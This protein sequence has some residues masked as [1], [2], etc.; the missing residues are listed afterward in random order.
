MISLEAWRA[1]I[2]CFANNKCCVPKIFYKG[3]HTSGSTIC[4]SI[5]YL[6]VIFVLPLASSFVYI[7][8]VLVLFLIKDMRTFVYCSNTS[9]TGLMN[10]RVMYLLNDSC[11]MFERYY[12]NVLL[13]SGDI[14]LNP[15]P[16]ACKVCPSR[17]MSIHIKKIVCDYGHRFKSKRG[18]ASNKHATIKPSNEKKKLAMRSKRQLE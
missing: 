12:Q 6:V 3:H 17:K 9:C 2:G 16:R 1:S 5:I 18:H 13:L 14:E 15:G 8:C 10:A 11:F 4:R 7:L